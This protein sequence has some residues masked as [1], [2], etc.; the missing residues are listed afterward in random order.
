MFFP[1]YFFMSVVCGLFFLVKMC[2]CST[3]VFFCCIDF[4][5]LNRLQRGKTISPGGSNLGE[6][7]RTRIARAAQRIRSIKSCPRWCCELLHLGFK[8]DG[9]KKAES[10]LCSK[11]NSAEVHWNLQTTARFLESL[12][13]IV[14][15]NS[16]PTAWKS[17]EMANLEQNYL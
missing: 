1:F 11:P 14:A 8:F 2:V 6:C 7:G 9:W 5:P 12:Q 4:Q 16:Q 15:G 13:G 17:W 10:F 3:I